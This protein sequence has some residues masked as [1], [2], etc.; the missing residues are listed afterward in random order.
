MNLEDKIL[1]LFLVR[2]HK[3]GEYAGRVGG[4]VIFTEDIHSSEQ[5]KSLTAELA[6]PAEEGGIKPFIAV[7]EEGGDVA[8]VANA[9]IGVKNTGSIGNIGKTGDTANAFFAGYNIGTYLEEYGFTLNFAPD[10]DVNTNP[11]NPV[12][13]KRAF[14]S[15]PGQVGEMANAFLDGLHAKNILGV[16]KHYPGH[17]DTKSDTH[18][19]YVQVD[20]NWDELLDCE[21]IPF[22]SCMHKADAI[23]A[24]HITLPQVSNDGLPASL[25]KQLIEEKLRGELGWD[26]LVVTDALEMGAIA[27]EF[28]SAES[29]VLALKAGCDLLL[30]P[31]DLGEA[32]QGVKDALESGELSEE[33]IDESLLRILRVKERLKD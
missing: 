8:R 33:R 13:G 23:M 29:S 9:H 15:D 7:D 21:L 30:M 16:I 19:G 18:K 32:V 11:S 25:S 31:A 24:A 20:K 17:G 26:G 4:Y 10:T 2:I 27:N 22:I 6:E 14:G 5:L 12:I 28:G 3:D 1:Q